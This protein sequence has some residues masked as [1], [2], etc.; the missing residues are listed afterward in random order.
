M[1]KKRLN[2]FFQAKDCSH[3]KYQEDF[4]AYVITIKSYGGTME[5]KGGQVEEELRNLTKDTENFTEQDIKNAKLV[6]K[7]GML[8]CLFISGANKERYGDL[9]T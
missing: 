2:L 5:Y 8:T 1:T 9:K 3:E 4:D 6:V 7:N